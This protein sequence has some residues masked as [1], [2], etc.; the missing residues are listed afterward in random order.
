[1]LKRLIAVATA[2]SSDICLVFAGDPLHTKTPEPPTVLSVQESG[3][4]VITCAFID[5]HISEQTVD[6]MG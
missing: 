2:C 4:N 6:L 1:M 5:A 3:T